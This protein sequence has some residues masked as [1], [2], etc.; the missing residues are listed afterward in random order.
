MRYSIQGLNCV[1]PKRRDFLMD[2]GTEELSMHL[3]ALK[4]DRCAVTP[5]PLIA[6]AGRGGAN[7][8]TVHPSRK[9]AADSRAKIVYDRRINFT[10]DQGT[11]D[12]LQFLITRK[13]PHLKAF[14]APLES[15]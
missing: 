13:I 2:I 11:I 5:D 7:L 15:R 9:I 3:R 8:F 14:T 6:I 10:G 12:T 1:E 4:N